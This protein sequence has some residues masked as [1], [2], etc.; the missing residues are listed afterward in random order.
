MFSCLATE[1]ADGAKGLGQV[2]AAGID[3]SLHR[4]GL[5]TQQGVAR[6]AQLIPSSGQRAW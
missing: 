6:E 3:T 1:V 4:D 5:A 2:I